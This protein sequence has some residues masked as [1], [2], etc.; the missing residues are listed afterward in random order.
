MSRSLDSWVDYIQTLHF[1]EIDLS[2]E[3]VRAVYTRLYPKGL[4]YRVISL[5]GTNGKGSTAELLASIYHQAHYR[6]GK[7]SSPHL[8]RFNE[9]FDLNGESVDNESLLS[10]FE[11]VEQ[12]RR[13]TPIT[14]FAVSYTHLTLPTIL[15]V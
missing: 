14:F 7:F 8:V 9:R 5:S 15:L 12:A 10:A 6:V 2:L 11:R 13:D 3:R 1:R 4:P